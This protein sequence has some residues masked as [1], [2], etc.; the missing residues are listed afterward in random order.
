[1]LTSPA[2]P[3]PFH[4]LPAISLLSIS[5]TL[6]HI[7]H[8]TLPFPP[9]LSSPTLLYFFSFLFSPQVVKEGITG[10]TTAVKKRVILEIEVEE[11]L[12]DPKSGE[13]RI[14]GKN[15]L[16]NP[17]VRLNAYHTLELV[18][19]RKF[20]LTKESWD[21]IFMERLTLA[22]DVSKSADLAAVIMQKGLAHV[23]LVKSNMTVLRAKIEL[24][25]PKKR[26]GS[27]NHSKALTR[28][29]EA[30]MN[31][32]LKHFDFSVVKCVILASPGFVRNDFFEV[33]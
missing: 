29:Y 18:P 3:S 2:H 27:S 22:C 31:A 24:S 6:S 23:C 33:R 11:V 14:R 15:K 5:S 26:T 17:H 9:L 25:V 28:F 32:V 19:T 4:S 13:I 10:S 12:Y 1:M 8:L 30:T 7:S 16:E 21:T 20:T